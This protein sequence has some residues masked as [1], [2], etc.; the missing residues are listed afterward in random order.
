MPP[1]IAQAPVSFLWMATNSSTCS[2]NENMQPSNYSACSPA[3]QSLCHWRL[4]RPPPFATLS[5]LG[6]LRGWVPTCKTQKINSGQTFHKNQS[7]TCPTLLYPPVLSF[8]WYSVASPLA[9]DKD[10]AKE[11]VVVG[12]VSTMVHQPRGWPC[13][14]ICPKSSTLGWN[15]LQGR[16]QPTL[17]ERFFDIISSSRCRRTLTP[18]TKGAVKSWGAYSAHSTDQDTLSSGTGS[19][20]TWL[21]KELILIFTIQFT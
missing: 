10:P 18:W 12:K 6:R 5:Q 20:A 14:W 19:L 8:P 15:L 4:G 13:W 3:F 17:S 9:L 16:G 21:Y 7:H 2:I 1:G 11:E